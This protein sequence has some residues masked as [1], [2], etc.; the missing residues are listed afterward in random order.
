MMNSLLSYLINP[1][2]GNRLYLK[3]LS[4]PLSRVMKRHDTNCD[5]LFRE[6]LRF[7]QKYGLTFR[8]YI[9]S[10]LL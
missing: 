2:M 3:A 1:L 7:W 6:T 5:H 8:F 10:R 9:A 4:V